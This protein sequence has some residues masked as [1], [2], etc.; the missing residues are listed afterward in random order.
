MLGL[1][2]KIDKWDNLKTGDD[3]SDADFF[4]IHDCPPLAFE[5]HQKIF[6]MYLKELR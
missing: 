5:C 1:L 4:S 2:I 6:D 3:A